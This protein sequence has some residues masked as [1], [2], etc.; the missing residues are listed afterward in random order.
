[1]SPSNASRQLLPPREGFLL[2][3]VPPSLCLG[4][5]FSALSAPISAA[6]VSG[7]FGGFGDGGGGGNIVDSGSGTGGGGASA[8]ILVVDGD[9]GGC[10]GAATTLTTTTT[11]ITVYTDGDVILLLYTSF[12][13]QFGKLM[14]ISMIHIPCFQSLKHYVKEPRNVLPQHKYKESHLR[15]VF[16]LKSG[17]TGTESA[18]GI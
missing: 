8:Y 16:T 9:G 13:P 5:A 6:E 7:G 3:Y 2:G 4:T 11:I 1:M 10:G 18:L 15:I 17:I 12:R 14:K